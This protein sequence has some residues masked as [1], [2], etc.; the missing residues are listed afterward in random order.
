[1][2]RY[3]QTAEEKQARADREEAVRPE[4]QLPRSAPARL[5]GH[6]TAE[7]TWRRIMRMYDQVEAEIVSRLDM[8]MLVDYCMLVDQLA[9]L[10]LMRTTTY[11]LWL[12][13]GARHDRLLKEAEAALKTNME[14]EAEKLDDAA[15][16]MAAKCLDAFEA[17]VKLDGRAD[18]KRDLLFK[19]RQSLYL[20]PR[21]RAGATP[22]QKA[23]EEPKDP[24][25]MLLDDVTDS[26]NAGRE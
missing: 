4:R 16:V 13:M 24:L 26:L 9:Q 14:D 21:A 10:D 18:R 11:K 6:P 15:V 8:D 22:G 23:K 7:E 1:M 25:E 12:E 3:H 2:I 5:A 20:T 17:V 19:M